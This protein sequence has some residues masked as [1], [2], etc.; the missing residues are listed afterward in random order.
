M[1]SSIPY[2]IIFG[3]WYL[4]SLLPLRLLYF[5]S[6]LLYFPCYYIIRYR[7]KIVRR[8]LTSSFPEK[9]LEEII[10]IEKQYYAFFCDYIMETVKLMSISPKEMDKRMRFEGMEQIKNDFEAGRPCSLYLGHYCNW[11]WISSLPMHL[12]GNEFCG[13]IYHPLENKLFD[14]LF[15]YIRGRFGAISIE[16]DDTFRTIME[17]QKKGV[18]NIVGYISDQVPGYSSMHYWPFFL[19]HDTPAFTGAERISRLVNTAV[20]YMDIRRP[21]R[22]YYVGKFIKITEEAQSV[23]KFHVTEQ[24]YRLLEESIRRNPPY[25]LWSHNRWKRTREEFNKMFSEEERKRMA[26]RL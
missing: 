14:R 9:S 5:L 18:P 20:Y 12:S 22:G 11:E 24:Y 3:I 17:W 8:N 23:P 2:Y 1:K 10:R 16:K 15:L 6:N 19:N 26:N 21:R 25:W 4:V 7:R 13:Q